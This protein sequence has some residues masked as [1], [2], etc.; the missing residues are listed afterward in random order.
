VTHEL[1]QTL[2]DGVLQEAGKRSV[3]Q[4]AAAENEVL[5]GLLHL[6]AEHG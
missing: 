6:R 2:S 1:K 3:A 5:L 4:L